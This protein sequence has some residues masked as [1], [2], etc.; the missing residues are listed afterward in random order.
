MEQLYDGIVVSLNCILGPPP[1]NQLGM[2]SY[3]RSILATL[4]RIK[5]QLTA[6]ESYYKDELKHWE[7]GE[8]F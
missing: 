7:L 5:E 1:L 3:C 4:S 8:E 6:I 2:S